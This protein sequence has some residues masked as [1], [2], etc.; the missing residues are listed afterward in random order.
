MYTQQIYGI[1][2]LFPSKYIAFTPQKL[3]RKFYF[4]V[5]QNPSAQNPQCLSLDF[6]I[7]TRNIST[8]RYISTWNF[9]HHSSCKTL[10]SDSTHPKKQLSS[11]K[12][13][14]KLKCKGAGVR[15]HYT[16]QRHTKDD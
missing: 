3:H 1:N 11:K 2:K 14:S 13:S 6:F 12:A 8:W 7:T 9:P 16:M 10:R 5:D 15:G 4:D